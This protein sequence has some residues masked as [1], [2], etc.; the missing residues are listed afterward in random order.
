MPARPPI[1]TP[2]AAL[3]GLCVAYVLVVERDARVAEVPVKVLL[4]VLA[5]AAWLLWRGRHLRPRAFSLGVPVLAL[6]IVLPVAWAAV[7]L[8]TRSRGSDV[9]RVEL[10]DLAEEASRFG[11]VLLYFP[12][13]DVLGHGTG[14]RQ[15][16]W[17]APLLVLA[18]LTWV[19]WWQLGHDNPSWANTDHHLVFNGIFGIV[20]D[21]LRAF[22]GQ[23]ALWPLL[24]AW[25]LAGILLGRGVV[26]RAAAG[27]L[28]L[29]ALWPAH[30]RGV[31]IGTGIAVAVVMVARHPRTLAI[32]R[33]VALPGA[34]VALVLV[35]VVSAIVL[36]GDVGRGSAL[37]DYSSSTRF[38]QAPELWAAFKGAPV[39]GSGLGARLADG[40]VRSTSAPWSF[41]LTYLQL[42]VQ[43]GVVG[44]VL[45]L[46]PVAAML[47]RL[48]REP[49][50]AGHDATAMGA[51]GLA[52]ALGLYE[53]AATNP[54]LVTSYGMGGLAV[55]LALAGPVR[56]WADEGAEAP[57]PPRWAWAIAWAVLALCVAGA[58]YEA[59]APR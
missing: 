18:V 5:G 59:L 29:S 57:D 55:A 7:A 4:C 49:L 11:Y 27:V 2:L 32:G 8:W 20:G 54:F 44:L 10:R 46:L 17:V 36:G 14:R 43:V 22:L 45:V 23:H 58:A 15:L 42:L 12:L 52:G 19:F 30:S 16:W 37:D 24:V 25:L 3:V 21:S 38:D 40:Y 1:R 26:P 33:R 56:T 6:G 13:A 9:A 28:A 51:V 47:V 48:V 35:V 34:A 50:G 53:A 31:W 39:L 41:E